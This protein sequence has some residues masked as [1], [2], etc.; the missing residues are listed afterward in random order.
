ME[1]THLFERN[2]GGGGFKDFY[3]HPYLGKMIQFDEHTFEMGWFNHQPEMDFDGSLKEHPVFCLHFV[4]FH[5]K[6]N[7]RLTWPWR[8]PK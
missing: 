2:L 6:K 5:V 7:S 1:N 8:L 3:F 4:K